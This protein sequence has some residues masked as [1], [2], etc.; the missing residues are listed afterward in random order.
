MGKL[1]GNAPWMH[2]T[3]WPQGWTPVQTYNRNVDLIIEHNPQYDWDQVS[4]DLIDNGGGYFSSLVGYMPTESSS[5][6]AGHYKGPYPITML[7]QLR[8]DAD[9]VVEW[10]AYKNIEYED[11]YQLAYD[12][13]IINQIK[14]YAAI[15]KYTDHSISADFWEDR[16]NGRDYSE[17]KLLE[18]TALMMFFGMKTR[19]YTT[20]LTS[21]KPSHQEKTISCAGGCA[22]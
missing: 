15:Q 12:I 8:S 2:K 7:T 16:R 19:Y 3:K 6:W 1:Y 22:G 11:R 10:V 13:P 5:K 21:T 18:E 17:E 14:H 4:Q 9:N 20:S